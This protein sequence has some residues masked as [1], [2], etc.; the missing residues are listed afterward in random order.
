MINYYRLPKYATWHSHNRLLLTIPTLQWVRHLGCSQLPALLTSNN[1]AVMVEKWKQPKCPRRQSKSSIQYQIIKKM[2]TEVLLIE[3]NKL[4]FC[5]V[6][7]LSNPIKAQKSRNVI[8]NY[9]REA[10]QVTV[11]P[12]L[13]IS[14]LSYNDHGIMC[15]SIFI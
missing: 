13:C 15:I 8:S 9:F 2:K 4:Q 11:L 6:Y 3:Q 7:P 1:T 12:F 5:P 10:L 14:S